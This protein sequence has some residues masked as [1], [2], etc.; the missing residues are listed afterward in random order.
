MQAGWLLASWILRGTGIYLVPWFAFRSLA[1]PPR[2][3]WLFALQHQSALSQELPFN[4]LCIGTPSH[5]SCER[6]ELKFVKYVSGKKGQTRSL[7][8]CGRENKSQKSVLIWCLS[9]CSEA[10]TSRCSLTR[11]SKSQYLETFRQASM[12][13]NYNY[14]KD[15]II[16]SPTCFIF[17]Y[18]HWSIICD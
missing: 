8:F 10:E 2:L 16:S 1:K 3:K 9:H 18:Y 4:A 15:R 17:Q 13:V 5:Y 14:H 12:A 7:E 6:F 11:A